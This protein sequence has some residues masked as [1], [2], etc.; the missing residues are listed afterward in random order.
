MFSLMQ[1]QVFVGYALTS[2]LS[3]S[4]LEYTFPAY[5]PKIKHYVTE[6]SWR[7]GD[8]G[9]GDFLILSDLI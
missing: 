8:G 9:G 5:I 3:F 6:T 1:M 7:D 2:L 4:N